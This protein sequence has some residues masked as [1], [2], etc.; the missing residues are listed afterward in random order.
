MNDDPRLGLTVTHRRY[1]PHSH[2][3]YGGELVDG[4]AIGEGV[5]LLRGDLRELGEGAPLEIDH[6]QQDAQPQESEDAG[7]EKR[8][9]LGPVVVV[10]LQG[11]GLLQ[12]LQP[13]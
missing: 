3:H 1:V 13:L 6:Q 5:G 10:P 9:L 4:V 2:A 7:H 12:R 8:R 11:H